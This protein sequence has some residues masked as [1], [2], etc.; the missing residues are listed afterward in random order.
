M[1]T[2]DIFLTFTL[3]E[4]NPGQSN[5]K[6]QKHSSV[7]Y[8]STSNPVIMKTILKQLLITLLIFTGTLLN[9]QGLCQV[10]ARVVF[11]F[12]AT[13][14][15][16]HLWNPCCQDIVMTKTGQNEFSSDLPASDKL[17]FN[18][19]F[20]L[21]EFSIINWWIGAGNSYSGQ[22]IP[23]RFDPHGLK[24]GKIYINDQLIDNSYTVQ[25]SGNNGLNIAVKININKS[26]VPLQDQ[27]N[28]HLKIDDRI[29]PEVHHHYAYKN[30]SYP[31]ATDIDITGW[32]IAATDNN[33]LDDCKIEIDYVRLYGKSGDNWISLTENQYSTYS[34]T[35]D[36]GLYSRY[37]FFPSGYDQHDPMPG[38]TNGNILTIYPSQNSKKV[39]HWWTPH[40][41]SPNGFNYAA[42]KM[43]CYL[44]ITGHALVQ[45]GIDFKDSYNNTHE[46]GCSDWYF[47][48]GGNWQE[49]IFDSQSIL[50]G[51]GK[52]QQA[53][54]Y[55]EVSYLK[56]EQNISVKYNG[57]LIGSYIFTVYDNAGK[58]IVKSPLNISN[59]IG[60]AKIPMPEM[61]AQLLVFNL[62][63]KDGTIGGKVMGY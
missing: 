10:K 51:T 27:S 11:P 25:N 37:P 62:S 7:Y 22:L 38:T 26:V 15:V 48:N 23:N 59:P 35:D 24:Y 45:A 4:S 14:I 49:V 36:G 46:L 29:P 57:I 5:H 18:I 19:S 9:L 30:I 2:F 1:I 6:K 12:N 61:A 32:V 44:R 16:L 31:S 43:V 47:E 63:G 53:T 55:L 28:I 56:N 3:A 41:V 58:C 60:E 13:N 8:L 42:Y 33:I 50:S 21:P 40:V 17:L 39:W 52:N 20:D 54:K 34:S